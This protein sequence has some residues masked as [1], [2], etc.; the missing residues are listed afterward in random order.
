MAPTFLSVSSA[1]GCTLSDLTVTGYDAPTW[2]EEDEEFVDGC[3]LNDFVV[4]FLSNTGTPTATYYW[5]D[6]GETGPAWC[7]KTGTEIDATA[8]AI[9]AGTAMWTKGSGFV[10]QSAGKV[11]TSD[12]AFAMNAS[13]Q[14]AAGNCMPVNL[15]LAQLTVSGYDAPTWVEEDEEFV[16]GC[17]LNDFVVNFL[18]NTG[19]PTATYYWVDDGETGPAWC[20]KTG[21]AIDATAINVPAGQGLWIK[22]SGMTL[23]IPAPEL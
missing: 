1:T 8:V 18:S 15:T 12:V 9:P 4:N 19:T 16:D 11:N 21:T 14:T 13:R 6:D 23:N 7:N 10:L 5:V 20:N 22:G 3:S 2:V 17:S